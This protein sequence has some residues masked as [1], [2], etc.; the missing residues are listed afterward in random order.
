METLKY[1]VIR[2]VAQYKKYCDILENLILKEDKAAREEIDLL[3][4]L[5]EKWDSDN[6]TFV[7]MDPIALLRSLMAEHQIKAKDLAEVVDLTKGSVSKILNYQKG[8]SK[9]T[10]RR[11]SNYFKVSQEAFNR[12]YE[13]INNDDRPFRD[14][15][16]MKTKVKMPHS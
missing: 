16:P 14:S 12:P 4:V 13:L 3:T 11:L 15:T 2:D 10:I 9:E 8:L 1:S 7:D 5:I 6:N